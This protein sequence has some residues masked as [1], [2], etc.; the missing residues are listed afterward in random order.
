MNFM[1]TPA[2]DQ[3]ID[4]QIAEVISRWM[5]ISFESRP[6]TSE[7]IAQHPE[8]APGLAECLAGFQQIEQGKAIVAGCGRRE[9][10]TPEDEA[11]F[12]VIPDFKVLGELGRGG[13]G[14]VYEARQLSLDRIVALKVLPF[15][16]V[17]PR[18]VKRFL[19][20]AETVAAL[21][22]PGIVPIYAV[23][24]HNGLN[25]FAMQRIDGCPLSQW[26][27]VA[28]FESR[29]ATLREVVRVGIEAA[30]ALE[31]AH[32]R[33]VIHRDVKPGNLLVDTTGNVWLTDFGLARRDVDVTATATGAMLGTPRYMS[34][35]QIS[36]YD[37]E[38]DARTDIYSLGAT[39]FEMATGRAPFTSESPLEL[40]TQIRRDEPTPPRQI[41]PTIPRTLELVIL[42]C[43]DKERDRRYAS[44]ADLAEDLKAIRDDKPISA[45]GLP[46][47][48][49]ASRFLKR[50]QRQVSA[51]AMT[52]VSTVATLIAITLLWQQ[53][54]QAKL[55]QVRINTPAGLYV[56]NIQP[57]V[58]E[59]LRDSR[60]SSAAKVRLEKEEQRVV[61][62]P[63]QQPISLPAGEY[64]V[65]LEGAGVPSQ[66]VD[67]V[68]KPQESTEIEYVDRRETLPQVDVFKNLAVPIS[69]GTL[70]VLGKDAFAIFD[71]ARNSNPSDVKVAAV[72]SDGMLRFSLPITEL[73]ATLAEAALAARPANASNQGDPPLTFAFDSEQTFQGDHN[74]AHS[75][76]ARIERIF[77][78]QIDLNADSKPDYLVTAARHAAI[79][80]IS[81]DGSILWKRHLPMHF[82]IAAA[83]SSYP[84]NG[85]VNEAIV[86][87]TQVGDLD[88]DGT[89]DLVINAA[90][91]DRSGFSR[92]YIFTLSG[93][94]G[95][96]LSVAP[97]PTIEMR[98][99]RQWPWSGLLR[100]R[101]H[102]S[103]EQRLHRPGN[104]RFDL[105][106][107]RSQTHD[108]YNE[109]WSGNNANSALY[110]L[111]PLILGKLSDARIA[112]TATG[113]A[114]HFINLADGTAVSPEIPLLN[115]ILRGPQSIQLADGKLAALVLTG[116]PGTAYTKCFLE[117]CVLGESQPRWSIPQDIGA[118]DFVAGAADCSF[119]MAVDLDGDGNDEV[120]SPTNPD[121]PF[122]WPQLNC[123]SATGKLLWSSGG[124]S[125]ISPAIDRALPVGDIDSDGVVDLAVI[126]L[127]QMS[128]AHTVNRPDLSGIDGLRLAIDF[129]SGK[130]GNRI[131]YRDEH[132]VASGKH[133]EVAEIDLIE[134]LGNE[135]VCSIVYGSQEELKL[136]SVTFA[137]DLTQHN[138]ATVLRGLT[139][140]ALKDSQSTV[141]K[142]RWFRRRS[143]PYANPAD[144]AVWVAKELKQ[145]SYPGENLIASWVS[146]N[147][148]PRLLLKN[149][150][151]S[152]RCFNPVDGRNIWKAEQFYFGVEPLLVLD[153]PD[154]NVDLVCNSSGNKNINPAFYDGETGQ[155][156]F[157]IESPKM[158]AIRFVSLDHQSPDR[159]IY[160]LAGA[161]TSYSYGSPAKRDQGYLLLKIDRL[162]G[163]LVWWKKCY[164]GTNPGNPLRPVDPL[165]VELNGDQV[166][167]LITGNTKNGRF[168]IE[169]I[170]GRS[171]KLIWALPLHLDI[172]DW[173]WRESWPMMTLVPSGNQQHLLVIDG[174]EKVERLFDLKSVRLQDGKELDTL[175]RKVGSILRHDVQNKDLS[176][177]VMSPMKR[178]GIVGMITKF[179]NDNSLIDPPQKVR[180]DRSFGMKMLHVDEQTG[181]FKEI[182]NG[183]IP[184][185]TAVLAE[186]PMLGPPD[187]I[188]TADMDGDGTLDRI[189]HRVPGQIKIRPA[190]KEIYFDEFEITANS[191]MLI[192]LEQHAGKQYLK[193]AMNNAEHSWYE[194]PGGQVALR[195]GQGLRSS[196]IGET[197]Y[198]RLLSHRTG[199]LLIGS[200]PEAVICA[201]VDMGE[202]STQSEQP[203]PIPVAMISADVDPRYRKAIVAHGLYDRKSF[204]DVIRL[205]LLTLGA[206]LM[207]FGY[208]YRLIRRRQWSLQTLLLA[209]AIFMLA[210]V[211]WRA[212]Q[213]RQDYYLIP[214]V[215]AGVMAA[216]SVWAVFTLMRHQRWKILG[217]SIALSMLV[218]T[219]LMLGA[220][221]TIPLRSPGMFGYWTLGAWLNS[222]CAAAA[223]IVMPMAV[224][225]AWGHARAKKTG[226]AP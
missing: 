143:G 92:P 111:P 198:P 138:S 187:S 24:V 34:A 69:D 60:D 41:D 163:R 120:L 46:V 63:M 177:H 171:G 205:A 134:R 76:F 147:Q 210:L 133:V 172:D 66:T 12:P 15:G 74:V 157:K 164:E 174:V 214:D 100:H 223:Q 178:D 110:V 61:T 200:T 179:P 44:A 141:T 152:V 93:R 30:E 114:V 49:T 71:P 116:I 123:Y 170:D 48:V 99:I 4:L 146:A 215:I 95:S 21:A 162:Q 79:A 161:D 192:D 222:V 204:A 224:G 103:S 31:H 54:E 27:A 139:A 151:G 13:M 52:L 221:A 94:D 42:K 84:K 209:P 131:G 2:D 10:E 68:V 3:D 153:R 104:T 118:Y 225:V 58:D 159:Y 40:L 62:T 184:Y 202:A 160:A 101:R 185:E 88:N 85:M 8:L 217:A 165:Q 186:G 199:T 77:A 208:V 23:G 37:E 102:F 5:E 156:R 14:V 189:E 112:I 72:N 7:L 125:G 80:A 197:P 218:A 140:L 18:T 145:S 195:F 22:H 206:I 117:L 35:E 81:G 9:N 115:P 57:H 226:S 11:V 32:Q 207:P 17:D 67:V 105:I 64:R 108:L 124:V 119:P 194:L 89:V 20:E 154:G 188:F 106:L 70:A 59:F 38:V 135:L 121:M 83:R 150:N 203:I 137:I 91:F 55:G 193:V 183:D 78:D 173:P 98:K 36:G 175:R 149:P 142:G 97:L 82:E 109:S 213:N 45:K 136:S 87:I 211:C 26:F 39:L 25:W 75:G 43:L 56:A 190:N 1:N 132:V 65:R 129:L 51:V 155:L 16:A 220:Q 169:A 216:L 219:L 86:G 144:A 130:T 167:D 53:S 6:A 28:T 191:G 182:D 107:M 90:L 33:G 166:T 73:D 180:T 126:G 168:S 122:K 127:S 181:K 50:N 196:R 212:L 158:D 29:A 148:Q 176:L 113:Q 19:R 47:W 128:A 96:E 201:Q